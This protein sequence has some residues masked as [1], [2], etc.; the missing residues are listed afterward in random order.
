MSS[1]RQAISIQATDSAV[2][3]LFVRTNEL[4]H[5]F[6]E[7]NVC[8]IQDYAH[9][10]SGSFIFNEHIHT[11]TVYFRHYCTHVTSCLLGYFR[12][13]MWS[14]SGLKEIHRFERALRHAAKQNFF[15]LIVTSVVLPSL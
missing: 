4:T 7:N 5:T 2:L 11:L 14:V 13:P 12:I 9:K 8:S 1:S 3:P 15:F 10:T 6:T